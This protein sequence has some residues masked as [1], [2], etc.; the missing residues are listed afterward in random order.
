MDDYNKNND[1]KM[2]I[3]QK[4]VNGVLDIMRENLDKVMTRDNKINDLESQTEQLIVGANS[5]NVNAKKLKNKMYWKNC[6]MYFIII[7]II[8]IIITVITLIIL[9]STKLKP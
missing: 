7:G 3:V 9:F 2:Q 8:L 1:D 5:F 6:K 4:Q